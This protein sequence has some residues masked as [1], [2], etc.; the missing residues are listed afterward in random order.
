MTDPTAAAP[1]YKKEKGTLG[2][3]CRT[4]WQSDKLAAVR[5]GRRYG[6]S[7]DCI[8]IPPTVE[9]TNQNAPSRAQG[10]SSAA[11]LVCGDVATAAANF[12]GAGVLMDI[13]V[14]N[15][16]DESLMIPGICNAL[17]YDEVLSV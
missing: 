9:P 10:A 15:G 4:R 13:E 6:C 2:A 1:N 16:V 12:I 5:R 11:D 8:Q 7:R 17:M 3:T 14:T